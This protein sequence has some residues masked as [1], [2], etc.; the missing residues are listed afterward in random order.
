MTTRCGWSGGLCEHPPRELWTN[1]RAAGSSSKLQ[2]YLAHKKTPLLK[3]R[4][5]PIPR[6]I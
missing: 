6:A 5:R 4:G 2:G 1:Q 3:P